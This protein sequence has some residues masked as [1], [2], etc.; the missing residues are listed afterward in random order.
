MNWISRILCMLGLH[1]PAKLGET[2]QYRSNIPTDSGYVRP[3]NY[4]VCECCGAK[5]KKTVVMAK[6]PFKWLR[7]N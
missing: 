5:W 4:R 1:G 3:Q 7:V 2:S 6:Y